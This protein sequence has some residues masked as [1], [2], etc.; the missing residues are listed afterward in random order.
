[1][2]KKI[3]LGGTFNN[4]PEIIEP[5]YKDNIYS[6]PIEES[7]GKGI[8][9]LSEA[10]LSD[11]NNI[12]VTISDQNIPIVVLFGPAECGKTMT[13]IRLTRF[14]QKN[15]YRVSPIRS[16]RPSRDTHYAAMCNS[17]NELV[18]SPNAAE[19]TEHIS[20]MLVGVLDKNGRSICQILEAPGELYF[21]PEEPNRDFPS[22]V[23]SI[24]GSPN[25]KI[26][27]YM[28]EP[29][30]KD[31][32][33][34]SNYV[35]RIK[36]LKPDMKPHDRA[37]FLYN[38]VDKTPYVISPGRV[39]LELIKNDISNMYPGIFVPFINQNPVTKIFRKYNCS[40]VPFSNGAF[41]KGTTSEGEVVQKYIQGVDDYPG[42]LWKTIMKLVRG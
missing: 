37:V 18:H 40:L 42:I 21:K 26:W 16:F 7:K 4:E 34:R 15:G 28:V 23:H 1:M 32:S 11:P 19:G 30:W 9:G 8:K 10:E 35:E 13:L 24:L 31:L 36:K 20:F 17:Y 3:D 6:S 12:I 22:Y 33:D 14:L 2:A 29:D 25:R 5:E 41:T 27:I 38:K 39:N